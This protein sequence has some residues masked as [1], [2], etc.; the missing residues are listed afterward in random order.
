MLARRARD[1]HMHIVFSPPPAPSPTFATSPGGTA[2]MVREPLAVRRVFHPLLQEWSDQGRAIAAV[3][4]WGRLQVMVLS[5]YGFPR[6]HPQQHRNETLLSQ[7]FHWASELSMP[8]LLGGDLNEN[9]SESTALSLCDMW[10][11]FRV[12][13]ESPTTRNR[14]GGLSA[15]CL[16]HVLVNTKM[17]DAGVKARVSHFEA[18]SDHFPVVGSFQAPVFSFMVSHWPRPPSLPSCRIRSPAWN[19]DGH[20]FVEWSLAA[21]HWIAR[22]FDVK[23]PPKSTVHSEPYTLP[24][25][26]TDKRYAALRAAYRLARHLQRCDN[27]PLAWTALDKKMY[28]L[29]IELGHS[30]DS[31]LMSIQKEITSHLSR[32]QDEALTVWRQKTRVWKGS[33]AAIF[34]FLKNL[35]PAKSAVI[36][37]CDGLSSHPADIQ[38]E[39]GTYWGQLEEWSSEAAYQHAMDTLD[40]WYAVYVPSNV[41]KISLTPKLLADT[42]RDIKVSATGPDAWSVKEIKSF[43]QDIW[44]SFLRVVQT[45]PGIW[46]SSALTLCKRIPIEKPGSEQPTADAIRP[47]DLFSTLLRTYSKAQVSCLLA[48]K[49]LTLHRT[50]YAASGGTLPPMA[51]YAYYSEM[52]LQG[53]RDIWGLSLDF[54]KL[55]NCVDPRICQRIA[56]LG[57]LSEMDARALVEPILGARK[58]WRLPHN[59]ASRYSVSSRGLPQGLCASVLLSELFLSVLIRRLNF[60]GFLETIGFIDDIS[61]VTRSRESLCAA[62]K[63]IL[64][65]QA[66][67][68]VSVA[69][70]KC[71]LWGSEDHLLAPLSEEWGIPMTDAIHALGTEWPLRR[72]TPTYEKETQRL[73]QAKVRLGRLQHVAAPFLSKCQAVSAGCLALTDYAAPPLLGGS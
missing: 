44:G 10:Q 3:V 47:I 13:D 64:E 55:F 2:I 30:L 70:N 40:D 16:D 43:T 49:K 41:A 67:F 65:F 19:F 29:G 63:I 18:I 36:L 14:A 22:A 9:P 73:N 59:A 39:L 4:S 52:I 15:N 27:N 48:W 62:Y 42:A 11:L 53:E 66:D 46:T 6:R 60:V 72:A 5:V 58:F 37:T 31:T 12:T 32:V 50:Q 1:L 38:S 28:A 23:V 69:K 61:I 34:R 8:L 25:L 68:E 20:T 7:C 33:D 24:G 51:R 21:E 56:V 17:L 57:G 26:R 45:S 35:P 71:E 54:R